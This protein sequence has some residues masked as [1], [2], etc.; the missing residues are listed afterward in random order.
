VSSY[1]SDRFGLT[2]RVGLILQHTALD[3][4]VVAT[5]HNTTI[6]AFCRLAF[7]YAGLNFQDHVVSRSDLMRP[8]EVDVLLGN[9]SK[10]EQKLNWY[11]TITLENMIAEM[12]DADLAR[13]SSRLKQ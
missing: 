6:R 8:A 5:G 3:D 7:S 10:A 9:A 1:K 2:C 4:Y 13:H 11:P 12:V